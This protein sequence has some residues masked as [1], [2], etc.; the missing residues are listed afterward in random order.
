M[1]KLYQL[2]RI[3]LAPITTFY[4]QS[5]GQMKQVNQVL[6]QFLRMFTTRQQDDWTDLLPIAEFAYNNVTH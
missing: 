3:Q 5:D 1:K 6:E 2:L 4:S